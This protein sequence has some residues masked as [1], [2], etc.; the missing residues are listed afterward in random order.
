MTSN[1]FEISSTDRDSVFL[2]PVEL[3]QAL[4]VPLAT[5]AFWRTTK[6]GPA[7]LKIGRHVRYDVQ[8]VTAWLHQRKG[9]ADA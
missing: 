4:A 6:Q 5:L 9:G 2:T 7:F 1:Q 8:D 3:S